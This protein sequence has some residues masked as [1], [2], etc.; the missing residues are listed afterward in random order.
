M[1]PTHSSIHG[2]V[3]SVCLAM[4][5]FCITPVL[6]EPPTTDTLTSGMESEKSEPI[7]ADNLEIPMDELKLLIKP[8]STEE[9][10]LEASGWFNA[11]HDKAK[12]VVDKELEVKRLN[13]QLLQITKQLETLAA[14]PSQDSP[15][16]RVESL[17]ALTSNLDGKK[18]VLT[19][20][21]AKLREQR[22][23]LIDRFNVVLDAINSTDGIKKDGSDNDIVVPY[24]R[25]IT[26]VTGLSFDIKD[27]QS[28]IR[29]IERWLKSEYGGIR[30]LKN[31]ALFLGILFAFWVL[32]LIFGALVVKALR[33]AK[34]TSVL[35]CNFLVGIVKKATMLV[36]ILIALAA[37]E[38]NT[39]P[40]LAA[41][42][43]AGF[44]L[45]FALQGTLSNFASGILMM[46][47]R[48]FDVGDAIEAGGVSGTVESMSLVSTHIKTNDSHLT[49]IPN[50]AVWGGKITNSGTA[51][52]Q[53]KIEMHFMVNHT[54]N[55][56]QVRE[57]FEAILAKHPKILKDPAPLVRL[58]ELT[59]KGM[60]FV[61]LPWSMIKDA[62]DIKWDVTREVKRLFDDKTLSMPEAD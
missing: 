19:E 56:D 25:Y 53:G 55:A 51:R 4:S 20:E 11:L 30:W 35:L 13:K 14:T 34:N 59:D 26:T 29:I 18:E 12:Q 62:G 1:T 52:T 48:P 50:N 45:A 42:G 24:R 22:T 41:L 2:L 43:A 60:K 54:N 3:L 37:L 36:G 57:S 6:A 23:G 40:L 9:L 28:T 27:T 49:I 58:D 32:S 16:P 61:V 39:S 5:F 15:D 31:I 47:Y 21:I 38:V 8:F 46:I 17:L 44:I 33:V 7:T 10:T